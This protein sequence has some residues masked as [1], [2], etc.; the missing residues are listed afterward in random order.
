MKQEAKYL[1]EVR[2]EERS[3][4]SRAY[5]WKSGKKRTSLMKRSDRRE[6]ALRARAPS[7][8]DS[9]PS[10][11]AMYPQV[12]HRYSSLIVI[13]PHLGGHRARLH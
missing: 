13:V 12:S 3:S 6:Y 10:S 5:G 11:R 8:F 4:R 9:R 2:H 7:F 1:E